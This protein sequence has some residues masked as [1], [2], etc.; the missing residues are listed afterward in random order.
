MSSVHF[1]NLSFS[2]SDPYVR[3]FDGIDLTLDTDWRLGLVAPNGRG[4]STLFKLLSGR[5]EATNG[6]LSC[7]VSCLVFPFQP[8]GL[9]RPTREVVRNAIAPFTAWERE[10]EALLADAG[11]ESSLARYGEVLEEYERLDGYGIDAWLE[12]ELAALRIDG[13]LLD[14]SFGTLSGGEQTRALLVA[15]FARSDRFA[16]IDEPTN[17]LDL[18]GR[19]VVA[20]YLATKPGFMVASHDRHF[21]DSCVD[22]VLAIRPTGLRLHRGGYADW[23]AQAALEEDHERR[24]RDNLKREIQS[25]ERAARQRRGW[26][27]EKEKQ[28]R[29]AFDKGRIGHLAAKQMKRALAVQRRAEERVAERKTLLRDAE[30]ERRLVLAGAPGA[31][32]AALTVCGLSIGY[33][34]PLC[35]ELSF[36]LEKGQR[37]AVVGPNGSGKSTLLRTLAGELPPLGGSFSVP[38][39]LEVAFASQHPRWVSGVLRDWLRDEDI[40]ETRFRTLMGCFGIEGDVFDRDLRTHSEGQRKKVDLCR[41]FLNPSHCLIWDEPMNYI[42]IPAREMIEQVIRESQPTMLF[43]EHDRRFI[44]RV[45]TDLLDLGDDGCGGLL[46]NSAEPTSHQAES[47]QGEQ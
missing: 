28:K 35:Q 30:K 15:L 10:M 20:D 26:S 43:V 4:K 40:D 21:L 22:H 25:F 29:G 31:P 2:Y 42:D 3:V 5:Q 44:E 19:Q 1:E 39:R 7:P 8:D 33:D 41:S 34:R 16:L 47:K 24:R 36:R 14:R 38:A 6:R 45:A 13:S 37:V 11:D 9:D 17:H 27:H 12:K 23:E 18:E 32:E 46:D